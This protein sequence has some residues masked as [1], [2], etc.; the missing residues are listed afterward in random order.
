[1]S[2]MVQKGRKQ[3]RKPV[4]DKFAPKRLA[5]NY[6]PPTISLTISIQLWNIWLLIVENSTITK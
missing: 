6:D 4:S 5:I 1:M 2:K 3:V